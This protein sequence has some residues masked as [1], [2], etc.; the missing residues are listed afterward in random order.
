MKLSNAFAR[1]TKQVSNSSDTTPP[2]RQVLS[3]HKKVGG[4][5]IP[6]MAQFPME[7]VSYTR[8]LL[9]QIIWI[10]LT[11]DKLGNRDG[12]KLCSDFAAMANE[13]YAESDEAHINFA[14]TSAYLN[15][16]PENL[17]SLLTRAEEAKILESLQNCVFP[18]TALY[19]NCPMAFLGTEGIE[20]DRSSLVVTI[21]NCV[22]RHFD[23]FSSPSEIIQATALYVRV[24]TGGLKIFSGIEL[25]EFDALITKPDSDEARRAA[26]F[27]RSTIM[28]EVRPD[29][30]ISTEW[31]KSFWNQNLDLDSC[32]LRND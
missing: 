1:E 13:V 14:L 2:K 4:R 21:K 6:P 30:R 7:E 24:K 5:F 32:E 22:E 17:D 31:S 9:P 3:D 12:I 27:V 28:M 23:R 20:P 19:E 25:P 10:G 26:S 11:I 15:L 8:E 16:T 29:S 18:L